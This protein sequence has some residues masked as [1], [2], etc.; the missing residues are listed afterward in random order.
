MINKVFLDLNLH[1]NKK[2]KHHNHF[3]LIELTRLIDRKRIFIYLMS[4]KNHNF[5]NKKCKHLLVPASKLRLLNSKDFL[6][7]M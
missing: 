7:F 1:G 6:C 4:E 5:S 2:E 3:L